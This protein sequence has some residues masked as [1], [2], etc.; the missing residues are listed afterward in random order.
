[1]AS[2][3]NSFFLTYTSELNEYYNEQS[4]S[5]DKSHLFG[6]LYKRNFIEMYNIH[7]PP[8]RINEDIGFNTM[9]WAFADNDINTASIEE[10]TYIWRGNDNSLTSASESNMHKLNCI[11]YVDNTIYA[12]NYAVSILKDTH[13][14]TIARITVETVVLLYLHYLMDDPESQT[15]NLEAAHNFLVNFYSKYEERISNELIMDSFSKMMHDYYVSGS[16][17]NTIIFISFPDYIQLVL[18]YT[19]T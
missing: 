15:Y 1:M 5:K 16:L 2:I 19:S 12:L 13:F 10:I 18:N 11:T 17:N 7:F 14:F 8:M 3:V 6:K 9:V 4:S